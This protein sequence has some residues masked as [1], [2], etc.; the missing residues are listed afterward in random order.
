MTRGVAA[1]KMAPKRGS[2]TAELALQS[3]FLLSQFISSHETLIMTMH[4]AFLQIQDFHETSMSK[5][6]VYKF[7]QWERPLWAKLETQLWLPGLVRFIMIYEN[8]KHMNLGRLGVLST[9]GIP[10]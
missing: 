1:Q 8:G 5:C 3:E 4:I 6:T 7:Q 9:L 10:D 2:H